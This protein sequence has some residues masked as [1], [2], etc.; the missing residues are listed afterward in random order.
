MDYSLYTDSLMVKYSRYTSEVRIIPALMYLKIDQIT[1][2]K[3][4]DLSGN[5]LDATVVTINTSNDGFQLANSEDLKTVIAIAGLSQLF[6]DIEG[7]PIPVLKSQLG[8]IYNNILFNN[9]HYL[10]LLPEWLT[11]NAL[12]GMAAILFGEYDT[13][14]QAIID[15]AGITSELQKR[16]ID[17]HVKD[18]KAL[19]VLQNNF[20]KFGDPDNSVIKVLYGCVGETFDQLKYNWINPL[21]TNAGNRLTLADGAAVRVL[22]NA[23]DFYGTFCLNTH[24]NAN[25]KLASPHSHSYYSL[26]D[27][28]DSYFMSPKYLP[29]ITYNENRFEMGCLGQASGYKGISFSIR[30]DNVSHSI[31]EGTYQNPTKGVQYA[32]TKSDNLYL[33]NKASNTDLRQ[34]R[35]GIQIGSTVAD[36]GASVY[37]DGDIILGGYSI[38][39]VIQTSKHSVLPCG[40]WHIGSAVASNVLQKF[41]DAIIRLASAKNY[42]Y[43]YPDETPRA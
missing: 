15:A 13:D 36:A 37:Y 43:F 23:I 39:G 20:V 5:G 11:G 18:L 14:A 40:Y 17:T 6:Y 28:T 35:Q 9:D 12:K 34:Y 7:N 29:S 22:R 41:N 30:R 2:G 19:N 10:V 33:T 42:Y 27:Q 24:F 16:L 3:Y 31:C 8:R 4:V 38:D 26:F 21:D 1:G 32:E 25:S